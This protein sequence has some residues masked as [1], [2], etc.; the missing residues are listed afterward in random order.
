MNVGMLWFDADPR[1][2][3]K[4]RLSRAVA[5]YQEKYGRVPNLCFIHPKTAGDDPPS[6]LADLD[7]RMSKKILPDHFWLGVEIEAIVSDIEAGAE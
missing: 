4:D 5:Y 2:N 6:N 1:V 7:V 3:L